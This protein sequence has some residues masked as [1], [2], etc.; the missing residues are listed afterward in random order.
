MTAQNIKSRTITN[1]DASPI[2]YD[3]AGY[4]I[5][6]REVTASDY[7]TLTTGGEGDATSTY[8]ILR[9]R[10]NVKLTSMKIFSSAV[11]D[12]NNSPTLTFDVGATYSDS[13]TDGTQASLQ[14]TVIAVNSFAADV[15]T[16]TV[17]K[18]PGVTEILAYAP[19]NMDE[20]LWEFLGLA[21]DP[22]GY[23]DV[24]INVDG[25]AATAVAG[26]LGLI[27]RYSEG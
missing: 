14:G 19:A 8:N 3:S 9:L 25:T 12:S 18:L 20:M 13:T 15:V 24:V 11:L 17:A 22:G 1:L 21:S 5:A 26:D 16:P 10:S 27:V 6:A 7:C 4:N 23:I 2:V